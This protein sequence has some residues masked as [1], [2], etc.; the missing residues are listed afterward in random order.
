MADHTTNTPNQT[1]WMRIGG[2]CMASGDWAAAIRSYAEGLRRQP[3][4]GVHHAANLERARR[5]WRQERNTINNKGAEHTTVMVVSDASC[6]TTWSRDYILAKHY[7]N[8]KYPVTLLRNESSR[9][10]G[11]M[12]IEQLNEVIQSNGF[13][14]LRVAA[15]KEAIISSQAWELIL[16]YPADL[17]HL[18]RLTLSTVL[19]GIYYK[20][21]WGAA[22][23]SDY[24]DEELALDEK[25]PLKAL[26]IPKR[27]Q[28][29]ANEPLTKV[30][31][32]YAR[33][34]VRLGQRFDRVT[35]STVNLQKRY[36]GEIVTGLA[37]RLS[38][39]NSLLNHRTA[40][41]KHY[42]I[43]QTAK[44]ILCFGA[45]KESR[46]LTELA[47]SIAQLPATL[48]T[49]L[50][51][52]EKSDIQETV[53]WNEIGNSL[54]PQ[55]L[56]CIR[57]QTMKQAA[58]L[59]VLAD[60]VALFGTEEEVDIQEVAMLADA[61]AT[62]IPIL[63]M[64]SLSSENDPCQAQD[65]SSQAK[66]LAGELLGLLNSKKEHQLPYV[67]Y[68]QTQTEEPLEWPCIMERMRESN[69]KVIANAKAL[70]SQLLD[71]LEA[72]DPIVARP[73][74]VNRYRNWS[75]LRI[76]WEKMQEPRREHG[77]VSIVLIATVNSTAL[78]GCLQALQKSGSRLK[79][80]AT[81]V[82]DCNDVN[83]RAKI[84]ELLETDNRLR[85]L[86]LSDFVPFELACNLAAINTRG[87]WIVFISD[88]FRASN[89]WLDQLVSVATGEKI[90]SSAI[91][92]QIESYGTQSQMMSVFE[93]EEKHHCM[94]GEVSSAASFDK[95]KNGWIRTIDG[96]CLAV[97][98]STYLKN[99]GFL[100]AWPP[101][102][103]DIVFWRE[104]KGTEKTQTPSTA[105]LAQETR[106]VVARDLASSQKAE[107]K[108]ETPFEKHRLRL[109][110]LRIYRGDKRIGTACV[111]KTL[112]SNI[113]SQKNATHKKRELDPIS[114]EE[115]I[116]I[117]TCLS[118]QLLRMAFPNHPALKCMSGGGS[119]DYSRRLLAEAEV[120]FSLFRQDP[121]M[122][123]LITAKRKSALGHDWYRSEPDTTRPFG[124]NLI[125]HARNMFGIGEDIR[126]AATALSSAGI[127]FCVINHPASNGTRADD[128]SLDKWIIGK[129][130]EGPYLF[131][132]V[133][134]AA[135]VHARWLLQ[136]GIR[137]QRGRY[138]I[139]CWPW[140]T[141]TWPWQWTSILD[142]ADEYWPASRLIYSALAPQAE[143]CRKPIRLQPMAVE[144]KDIIK[145]KS[146]SAKQN[147]RKQFS[148][149]QD[150]VIYLCTFDPRSSL[151]RK[152]PAAA[153][154]AFNKAFE[155]TEDR[156]YMVVKA[157][158]PNRLIDGMEELYR[159]I[160]TDQRLQLIEEDL[161]RSSL[162][163]LYS[164]CD[165]LISLHRSE[166]YGRNVFEARMLGLDVIA[167]A[168]GGFI[169]SPITDQDYYVNYRTV[170]VT[171][172]DYSFAAGH[173]WAEPD[174]GHAVQ[175]I[176][177]VYFKTR[178]KRRTG[179][180][181]YKS[182]AECS[183]CHN[184]I[185]EQHTSSAVVGQSYQLKLLDALSHMRDKSEF[186]LYE[187]VADH[188]P[189]FDEA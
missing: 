10:S 81:V 57:I 115:L 154:R 68:R 22:V 45:S 59:L 42:D 132:L 118:L 85:P 35:V 177:S 46:R 184:S 135:P 89:N 155:R 128:R 93:V 40:A 28:N 39:A 49:Q 146:E 131:N 158:K 99:R 88:D 71:A 140:E 104:D 74:K 11:P 185:N 73:F 159:L 124:V 103:A 32:S 58:N 187:R 2:E 20:L 148:L 116:D 174:I 125:G 130:E 143:S 8:L 48:K 56:I 153:I 60:L 161:D 178:A 160:E 38:T 25:E 127:P 136:D 55:H 95:V 106:L 65:K 172:E 31:I 98:S 62:E 87:E 144:I 169:D 188:I 36:G 180:Q 7:M 43:S 175:Q 23:V 53:L 139:A 6:Q 121:H 3:L 12:E 168:Y 123:A 17:V 63:K 64:V 134:M 70:D 5:R 170:N 119:S 145:Y 97:R 122:Q 162:L 44:V 50:V 78:E 142:L 61:P 54:P 102:Q 186:L 166:G 77:L 47:N 101:S 100:V 80:E 21:L 15:E 107:N 138:T 83:N 82:I 37:P 96:V 16:K 1:R 41:R 108:E 179:T 33:I 9:S 149:P 113:S 14:M 111:A 129:A 114:S 117:K 189:T 84:A 72:F 51:L 176:L 163:T 165:C 13:D 24:G 151:R 67:T 4:L 112:L 156:A 126:M 27:L 182:I 76:D 137:Q 69:R 183:I 91:I 110:M 150:G 171:A 29:R 26:D 157:L 19:Y 86:I 30:G 94:T 66:N 152:N 92:K 105:L 147:A 141:T 52:A 120:N 181:I 34:G 164:A 173:Q 90:I 133:C 167:T 79:W 75:T 109:S 18:T